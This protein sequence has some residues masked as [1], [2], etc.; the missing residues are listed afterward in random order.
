MESLC[1]D[2]S[3]EAS[4]MG[5]VH[6]YVWP[7]T[8]VQKTTGRRPK[9]PQ[10]ERLYLVQSLRRTGSA[11]V[12][13]GPTPP[14]RDAGGEDTWMVAEEKR[15]RGPKTR[16]VDRWPPLPRDPCQGDRPIPRGGAFPPAG[17]SSDAERD[18]DRMLPLAALGHVR[19]F[20]EV[21]ALPA[22]APASEVPEQFDGRPYFVP[23]KVCYRTEPHFLFMSVIYGYGDIQEMSRATLPKVRPAARLEIRDAEGFESE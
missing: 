19:F 3:E 20:E 10:G 18:C 16:C 7:D 15:R 22:R 8:A 5:V 13:N 6:A 21:S 11:S 9:F 23:T 14:L 1:M 17:R 2:L 4:R 12:G